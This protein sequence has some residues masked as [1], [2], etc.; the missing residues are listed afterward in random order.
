[1]L[2]Q[3]TAQE[4]LSKQAAIGPKELDDLLLPEHGQDFT[5]W[6]DKLLAEKR[7]GPVKQE[8]RHFCWDRVAIWFLEKWF[9]H[10]QVHMHFQFWRG[11][12][13]I[14]QKPRKNACFLHVCWFFRGFGA[15]HA[16]NMH[17]PRFL[18]TFGIWSRAH[19]NACF[20]HVFCM[21]DPGN[22]LNL[23]ILPK[24]WFLGNFI[25]WKYIETPMESSEGPLHP[26]DPNRKQCAF[27][28]SPL[29]LQLSVLW[30]LTYHYWLLSLH[31]PFK[32]LP[33][34]LSSILFLS[35]GSWLIWLISTWIHL[36]KDVC[37]V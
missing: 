18:T 19:Q 33:L 15:Q 28:D 31:H 20:L 32:P 34:N 14:Y 22:G 8:M 6:M 17:F 16:K 37:R 36:S 2:L 21:L 24:W 29:E 27:F 11:N 26:M 4:V 10:M 35:L 5:R 9:V 1:M 30:Y 13:K 7:Q 25:T 3:S 12:P 23:E